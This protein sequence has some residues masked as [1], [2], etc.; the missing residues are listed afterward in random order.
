MIRRP[1]RSTL[2]PY[3]TLFRSLFLVELIDPRDGRRQVGDTIRVNRLKDKLGTKSMPTAELTLD[4]AF[5]TPVGGVTAGVRKISGMLNVTRFHNAMGASGGM[6]RGVELAVA[7]SRVREAGGR[8]LIDQPLHVET[9]ADL[10][11]EAEAAFAFTMRIA[12]LMA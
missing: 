1:P 12:H 7:Y 8:R 2:F 5:A 11:V 3:T 4:G 6:R 9:I 10:T